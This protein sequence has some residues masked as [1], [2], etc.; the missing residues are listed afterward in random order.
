MWNKMKFAFALAI[1]LLAALGTPMADD[2]A[3]VQAL[4]D[5]CV[6]FLQ[7][8]GNPCKDWIDPTCLDKID[9][10]PLACRPS[11]KD[12]QTFKAMKVTE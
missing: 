12:L 11:Q 3:R 6:N 10:R 1:S 2:K 8:R 4:H 5:E 9:D 7:S